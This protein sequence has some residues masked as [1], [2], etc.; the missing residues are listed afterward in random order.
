MILILKMAVKMNLSI[1]TTNHAVDP[2]IRFIPKS[3][4]KSSSC[5]TGMPTALELRL[6][7]NELCSTYEITFLI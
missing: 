1:I 4:S 2:E 6:V 3:I 5:A 7:L